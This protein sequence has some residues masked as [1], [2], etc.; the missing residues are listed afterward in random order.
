[1]IQKPKK[2]KFCETVKP[3]FYYSLCT[4]SKGEITNHRCYYL[5]GSTKGNK[6]INLQSFEPSW[7]CL[8]WN[9]IKKDKG[10][11]NCKYSE[12]NPLTNFPL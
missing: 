10:L 2:L 9:V 3:G 7:F 8:M 11:E 12:T 4:N 5:T 6:W 1:M